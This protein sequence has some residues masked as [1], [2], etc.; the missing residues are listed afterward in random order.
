MINSCRILIFFIIQW[1]ISWLYGQDDCCDP[2]VDQRLLF[3]ARL[4]GDQYQLRKTLGTQLFR[5]SWFRGDIIL[6]SGEAVTGINLAYN[7]YLDDLL[8]A[9]PGKGSL[10][11]LDREQILKF[12]L[13]D[14]NKNQSFVFKHLQGSIGNGARSLDLFARELKE[15]SITL[16]V[17]QR[18]MPDEK[19]DQDVNGIMIKTTKVKEAIPVYLIGLSEH[20]FLAMN[21]L[22]KRS[23]YNV[24]PEHQ[25][26]L[27]SLLNQHHMSL[28]NE[29]DLVKIIQLMENS[30]ILKQSNNH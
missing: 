4:S 5:D 30:Q 12:V 15:D 18:F 26:A 27:K 11:R 23:L 29:H 14:P 3:E 9:D 17:T 22:N 28:L 20:R 13:Y 16:H 25:E 6:T 1:P 24:F 21:K 7:G 8:F 2:K 10:I 19:I